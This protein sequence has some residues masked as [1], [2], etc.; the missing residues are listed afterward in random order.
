MTI[1]NPPQATEELEVICTIRPDFCHRN[2]CSD[3]ADAFG[4]YEN[5]NRGNLLAKSII[6]LNRSVFY[7]SSDGRINRD[8]AYY[9]HLSI[10]MLFEDIRAINRAYQEAAEGDEQN[11][12]ESGGR[13]TRLL[14]SAIGADTLDAIDKTTLQAVNSISSFCDLLA[15][16][17]PIKIGQ[18]V[19]AID[20]VMQEIANIEAVVSNSRNRLA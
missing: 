5:I 18:F 10:K 12:P 14:S 19:G 11:Q 3:V 7:E 2:S 15:G 17:E 20:L 4:Y 16:D 6:N 8:D 13:S 9:S 1:L